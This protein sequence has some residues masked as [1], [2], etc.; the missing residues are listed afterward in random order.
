MRCRLLTFS[1]E[2]PSRVWGIN[3]LKVSMYWLMEGICGHWPSNSW[4]RER[5]ARPKSSEPKAAK[6][7]VELRMPIY[8][9]ILIPRQAF[10]MTMKNHLL[11]ATQIAARRKRLERC[12]TQILAL[13]WVTQGSL[14][15]SPQGN[16]RWT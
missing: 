5:G 10:S 6:N 15:Q 7:G 2:R 14:S 3:S 13:D 8:V 16:W 4:S 1:L 11:S 9:Y 12:K